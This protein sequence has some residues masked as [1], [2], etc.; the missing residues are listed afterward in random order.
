MKRWAFVVAALYLVILAVLTVPVALLAFVRQLG[1]G[2]VGV[3][4]VWPY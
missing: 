1:L 4:L 3:Y 2:A